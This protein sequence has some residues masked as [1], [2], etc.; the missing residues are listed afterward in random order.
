MTTWHY[1]FISKVTYTVP[2]TVVLYLVNV[3]NIGMLALY[4]SVV[5]NLSPM[6]AA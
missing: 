5:Q 3:W 6:S 1:L 4:L 2:C